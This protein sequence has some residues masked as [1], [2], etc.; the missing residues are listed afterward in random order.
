MGI[1]RFREI[2]FTTN[3]HLFIQMVNRYKTAFSNSNSASYQEKV[4]LVLMTKRSRIFKRNLEN[5]F[6]FWF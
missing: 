6:I 3:F 1:F 5:Y 2:N 4:S